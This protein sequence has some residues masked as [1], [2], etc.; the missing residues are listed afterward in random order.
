MN[1]KNNKE[2]K[3]KKII[4][5]LL[6][7]ALFKP[8]WLLNNESLG[9]GSDDM[10]YW[11]HSSTVAFDYDLDY[12]EDY[13]YDS[14]SYNEITNTPYHSP[15]SAYATAIFVK[16]FS[17]L[18]GDQ[19]IDEIRANPVG[20]YS[21]L[22]Y[23]F[24]S[25]F[26]CYLGFHFFNKL[27]I[28]KKI[29]VNKKYIFLL[30]YVSTIVHYVANRFL[31]SH[32]FEFFLVVLLL[33]IYETKN[34]LFE[35]KNFIFL[36]L[37]YFLLSIT[38]PSTFIYSLSLLGVYYN[39]FEV[40]RKILIPNLLFLSISIYFYN[41]LAQILHKQSSLLINISNNN[42]TKGMVDNL[43][44]QWIGNGFFESLNL[45]FSPS[46]GMAWSTPVILIGIVTLLFNKSYTKKLNVFQKL[47]L[48][49][50]FLGCFLV[51]YVWQGR[52]ASFGQR[53]LIGIIPFCAYQICIYFNKKTLSPLIPFIFV[54]YIGN[55]FLYSSTNLTLQPGTTLWN[56]YVEWAGEG[57]YLS[58][59]YEILKIENI[60]SMLS[61]TL[62]FIDIVHFTD[63]LENS[64]IVSSLAQERKLRFMNYVETYNNLKLLYL[65][66]LNFMIFY[67][68]Y[69]FERLTTKK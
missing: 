40:K 27:L 30:M 34:N 45:L 41:S 22:G 35:T 61:R 29:D 49:S 23:L 47:S 13:K 68:S 44:I 11:I 57:Y 19:D 26:F 2:N 32:S 69:L 64:R 36:I 1:V 20:S 51:L 58:L 59:L 17:F 63:F 60:G 52:E 37:I 28:V 21:L 24:G 55:L 10:S 46:L 15:G 4:F 18:D 3:F 6:I 66:I 38:R 12:S 56:T 5:C 14:P 7:V 39:R 50:Y 16:L 67:F 54:A 9:V 31:M 8:T 48:T 42:T 62:F 43:N 53:L 65:G 33:Y 25:L